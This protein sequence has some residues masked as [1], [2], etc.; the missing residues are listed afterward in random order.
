MR[1]ATVARSKICLNLITY[2]QWT[3]AFES[4]AL[5]KGVGLPLEVLEEAGRANGQLTDLMIQYMAL[6]KAPEAARKSEGMQ[7]YLRTNM[8]VAE[9]DLAHA[10]A[11]ARGPAWRCQARRWSPS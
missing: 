4:A 2:L 10:L 8:H 5:A 1:S 9:K 11:L 3:A 7:T 6:H